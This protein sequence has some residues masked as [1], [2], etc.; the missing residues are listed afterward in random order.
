MAI[1]SI[2]VTFH[3]SA[4]PRPELIAAQRRRRVRPYRTIVQAV[5]L[6]ALFGAGLRLYADQIAEFS[7][8]LA[9]A[10]AP[11]AATV[12]TAAPSFPVWR[13]PSAPAAAETR[14]QVIEGVDFTPV[15]SIPA[16]SAR[17]RV[18]APAERSPAYEGFK[19]VGGR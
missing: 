8:P 4:E 16:A 19:V 7:R 3:V 10:P 1:K 14:V 2:P 15:A 5:A 9:F 17:A 18:F 13:A 12:E 11:R 6:V